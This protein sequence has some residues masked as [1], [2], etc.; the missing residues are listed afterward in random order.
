VPSHCARH[1]SGTILFKKEFNNL[2]VLYITYDIIANMLNI[3]ENVDSKNYSTMKIGGQFRYFTTISSIE[4]LN[5]VYAIAQSELKYKNTPIFVLGGGSN[6]IFSDG[7][8][9]V[10]ALKME[11]KGFEIINETDE[12][13]D[14]KVGAGENWDDFVLKTIEMNVFGIE[15]LSLIPGTVGASPVQNIGAYGAEVKDTILEVEVFDTKDR[16]IKFISNEDC[17]FG[18]RDSI[19]KN[20][21]KGRYIITGVIFRFNK[22]AN[23]KY[24]YEKV[25]GRGGREPVPDHFHNNIFPLLSYP[26]VKRYFLENN[27]NNPSLEQIRQAIIDIRMS[28]LP[29]PKFLPNS[30]SFFKNPIVKNSLASKIMKDYPDAKFFPIDNNLTKIPAGWLIE[31]AGFKGQ[32]FGEISVYDNNALVLVNN[33]N[34]TKEDLLK[35]KNKIIKTVSDKFG[36]ILEQETEII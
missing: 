23:G 13:V 30:G 20:E 7:I 35:A 24:S 28:K 8:I 27:I 12:Y 18:Y 11:I 31:K 14:I 25:L 4:E 26:G 33:G 3:Q 15:S 6:T 17:K 21:A 22:I 19:F 36:I 1:F 34:A 16:Q 2:L 10:F 29:D 5:S 32:S 9:N